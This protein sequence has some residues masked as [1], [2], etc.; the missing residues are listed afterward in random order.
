M[1][2][3]TG[4]GW[5]KREGFCRGATIV[6]LASLALTASSSSFGAGNI[7]EIHQQEFADFDSRTATV[8]PTDAQLAA[9]EAL[10]ATALWN[11]FG[12]PQS[13]IKHGG[14]L[15]TGIDA[16]DAVT[17]ARAWIGANTAL[18]RLSSADGLALVR[19][20]QLDGTDGHAVLFAQEF[21]GVRAGPDGLLTV[22]VTGTAEA[23]WKVAYASSTLTGDETLAS[24]AQLSSTE[25]WVGAANAVGEDVSVVDVTDRERRAGWTNLEVAGLTGP[26]LVRRVAFPTPARG[27][28][29]AFETYVSD[30]DADGGL[31]G[32]R[33]FVDAETGRIL[34]RES[35][36]DQLAADPRWLV[37]PSYTHLAL[38]F[39]PWN[40]P[41]SNIRDMW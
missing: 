26:Q 28:R 25:A 29:A 36:V 30:S 32:Y 37:F 19:D 24:S 20:T 2:G 41:T 14:F 27:V 16:R 35:A 10:G 15:A 7:P 22:A 23:G 6:V 17:A 12:T 33:Q 11:E 9:V 21:D 4:V 1:G 40:Y 39:F 5:R 8:G 34:F 38:D 3:F 31:T 18:F 13:L